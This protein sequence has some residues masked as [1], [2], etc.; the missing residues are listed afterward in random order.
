MGIYPDN[1]MATEA[2][3]RANRINAKKG[4]RPL[5]YS[6]IKADEART[7]LAQMVFREITPIG[8][9]LLKEAKKGNIAAIKELFDRSFGKPPQ[10][11]DIKGQ[12]MMSDALN[13]EENDR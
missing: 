2:Q 13:E 9:K 8:N 12:F 5:N 1:I 4:G 7:I 3:I 11:L 10:S 6:T